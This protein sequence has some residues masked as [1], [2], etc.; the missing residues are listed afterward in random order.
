MKAF[1]IHLPLIPQSINSAIK[2]HKYLE[3]SGLDAELFEGTYGWDAV[4]IFEQENREPYPFDIKGEPLDERT[5]YLYM[6]HGVMGCFH[7]HFRLWKRCIELNEPILIFEDDVIF[8]RG[9]VPVEWSEILL[10]ATGKNVYRD[11]FYQDRLIDPQLEPEAGR[12]KGKNMPGAVGYGITPLA[13]KKLV[14]RYRRYFM[15]ADNCMNYRIVKLSCHTHLMGRAAVGAGDNK[16]S[17]TKTRW[18]KDKPDQLRRLTGSK[19]R[20]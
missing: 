16:Q 20:K 8:E 17:L 4:E 18:W 9:F 10:L 14:T 15:P 6:R 11:S 13:A 1:V 19:K 5:R 12:F 3:D 7:S 2:T